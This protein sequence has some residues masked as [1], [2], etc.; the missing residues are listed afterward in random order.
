MEPVVEPYNQQDVAIETEKEAME[1]EQEQKQGRVNEESDIAS[2]D[3]R[4]E[5]VFKYNLGSELH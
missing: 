1:Q 4:K 2:V 3:F 5:Y